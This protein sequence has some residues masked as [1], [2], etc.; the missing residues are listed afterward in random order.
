MDGTSLLIVIACFVLVIVALNKTAKL[1][2]RLA[3]LK[4]QLAKLAEELETLRRGGLAVQPPPEAEVPAAAAA[5]PAALA[6]TPP[7]VPTPEVEP[8]PAATVAETVGEPAAKAPAAAPQPDIEQRLAARWF[9]WIGGIAIAVGGLLFVK[10]AYD[11]QLIPP[12]L[13]IVLGL[14]L[15]AVLVAAGEFVRRK[16]PVEAGASYVPAALSA[17]GLVTAFGSIYAAYALYELISPA[18]AFGGLA[19][20][21]L[22]ALALSRLQ[23][24]LIAALGLIGSY[25]TP[26]LIPSEHPSAWSFF[27]Y[28]LVILAASFA[29]LR[30]RSWWWLGLAAIAGSVLWTLLWLFGGPMLPGHILPIGLFAH[31]VGLIAVFGLQGRK[32]LDADSGSLLDGKSVT[33]PLAIA[34]A[35]LAAE[36]LLTTALAVQ[37]HH[38]GL[39]LS[40]FALMVA[41]VLAIAWV[42]TGLAV[43]APLAGLV[44][45]L[46]QLAWA[47]VAMIE[48]AMDETGLWH[49]V[50]G[51]EAGRFLAWSLAAGAVLALAG[52]IGARFAPAPVAWASLG[53]GASIVFL[54]IAWA[55]VSDLHGETY[56]AVVAAVFAA[57]L[58]GLVALGRARHGEPHP[59]LA[60]G[61]LSVGVAAL[62][63]FTFDRLFD[64]IWLTLAIAVLGLAFAALCGGLRVTLQAP[65][66]AALGSLVTLRLFISRELWLDD[67]TLPLGAHWPLY[68]YGVPAILFVITSRLLRAAGHLRSAITL[69]GLSLGL[70]ISLVSLELRVLISGGITYEEPTFLEMAAHILTW[71]GAAYGL[72]YRQQLYSSFIATWGAR[73]LLGAACLAIVG[74]S[75]V[76]LNPVVTEEPVPGNVVFNALLLAY[77]APVAL[78]GLISRRLEVLGWEKLRP[79]AG[80]FALV[81]ALVY[82]TL[83][84]K[85]V[86]QGHLMVAW[87]LSLAESY[88]YSAVWL[89]SSLAL[90]IAGLKLD[91]QYIRYAGLGVMVLVVLKV[92]LWD[93]SSLEGLYR[94]A[95]FIGLGLS[96]VGIGWLYQRFVQ[97]PASVSV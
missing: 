72:M 27:P 50:L 41:E 92:F 52:G 60:S 62:L 96:L 20:V 23:G 59:N 31:A 87:S 6:E 22:G 63:V 10:Y 89:V 7:A 75:L 39:A 70:V 69:E 56:W 71:L 57:V 45:V 3:Q 12:A 43:L 13:Q 81:L 88:A 14:L 19:V 74:L 97:R 18:L 40:L 2:T 93:M 25:G 67:R 26:A 77:L 55:R 83:E 1:E 46:V 17:A 42:K 79:A 73:L 38:E 15:G 48:W 58:L 53:A 33:P 85:R 66:A 37:S 24:P 21:A 9:V 44:A 54:F 28:L 90:F 36:A 94:I 68:G 34:V 84:T 11:N 78:F 95:S 35:G 47:D 76:A 49:S 30:G 4:L 8:V 29:V 64:D 16:S 61:L 80:L 5:E 65:I 91:R 86:F 82:V 32:I 51:M